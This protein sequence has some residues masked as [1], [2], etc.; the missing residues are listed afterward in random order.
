MITSI[1]IIQNLIDI[2]YL[3]ISIINDTEYLFN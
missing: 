1:D 2:D 3:V